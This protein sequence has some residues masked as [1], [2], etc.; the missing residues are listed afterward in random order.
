MLVREKEKYFAIGLMS[1]TSCD[2]VDVALLETDGRDYLR[3]E[4][5]ITINYSKAIYSDIRKI[6]N[7]SFR[8]EDYMKLRRDITLFHADAVLQFL[9]KFDYDSAAIDVIGFHG[10]TIKHLPEQGMTLQAGDSGLLASAT[11][12]DV[13][14]DFRSKDIASGG[15]GAPLV[16]IFLKAVTTSKNLSM[17]VVFLNIGGISNITYINN[18]YILAY[19]VGPGNAMID[20]IMKEKLNLPFDES[21][22]LAIQGDINDN[23]LNQLLNDEYFDLTPPK[24][25]DRDYFV[26]PQ[27][28]D[29]Q[30]QDSVATLSEFT[31][32]AIYKSI[33]S[34]PEKPSN[35]IVY[36][37]GMYNKYFLN[38]IME[39]TGIKVITADEIMIK[40]DFIEAYAFGYLA[41]RYLKKLP[42]T[43]PSTTSVPTPQVGGNL[44]CA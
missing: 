4:E 18:D 23:V 17:P 30:I 41:T 29:M 25:L 22:Q 38:R 35:V 1:G 20:D 11:N 28:Y 14:G 40:G 6:A 16:P 37:G 8:I 24:S 2:G 34:L 39:S 15:Q 7:D 32:R 3:L 42:I 44:C 10:H 33:A 21:G 5:G 31:V 27:I 12:I 26:L 9:E 43:F 19:D 36:G 13:I